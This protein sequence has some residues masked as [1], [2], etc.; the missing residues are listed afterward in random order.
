[1]DDKSSSAEE[2]SAS[3][4]RI[5]CD[6]ARFDFETTETVVEQTSAIGQDRATAALELAIGVRQPGYNAYVLGR[7]GVGKR[8]LVDQVL[9]EAAAARPP[10]KDCCYVYNF[11]DPQSPRL[12]YLPPGKGS[13]LK[14]AMRQLVDELQSALKS[15][16]ES[17]E[18]RSRR[19][20]ID[21]EFN[22]KPQQGFA[23]LQKHAHE[24]GLAVLRSPAGIMVAPTRNDEVLTNEE[25]HK[26]PD[27]ERARLEADIK[28]IETEFKAI[29]QG[30]P[31]LERERKDKLRELNSEITI[32]AVSLP[33]GRLRSQFAR[34][35]GVDA[36]INAIEADVIENAIDLVQG[37]PSHD[38]V[39]TSVAEVT[40]ASPALRRFDINVLVDHAGETT[41]PIV[42]EDSPTFQDLLGTVEHVSYMGNLVTDFRLIKGGSLHRA[43]GGYLIVDVRKLLMQPFAYEGLKRALTRGE[44]RIE[45]PGKA[46][47]LLS[48]VTLAPEPIPLDVKVVLLGDRELYY[49]ISEIDP[50]FEKLFKVQ[51]DFAD[52]IDRCDGHCHEL[53]GVIAEVARRDQLAPFTRAAVARLIDEQARASGEADKLSTQMEKL[54]DV[55]R[56]A[57]YFAKRKS[58]TTVD[59]PH[60]EEAIEARFFRASRI[61]DRMFEAID[62]DIVLIETEGSRIG[63]INAL[64]ALQLGDFTFGRPGRITARVSLGKGGVVD[65]EREVEL[66]GPIHSKGVMILSGFVA[67]RYGTDYPHTLGATLVFE[68]SYAGIEGDSASCAELLALLSAISDVPLRQSIAITGSINQHGGVQAIG[69]VNEKIEGFYEVCKRRGLEGKHGV[70]IPKANARHLMLSTEVVEA[71]SKGTFH[72]YA[73]STVDQAIELMTGLPA[74]QRGESGAFPPSS[75]NGIV[76]ARLR[77]FAE[78]VVA[79]GKGEEE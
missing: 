6:A 48:T 59:R 39:A 41:A 11:D 5:E 52:E 17:E 38:V 3:A 13:E 34:I 74:G 26:L 76:E 28:A 58:A 10:A 60:V 67:G 44:L 49:R 8:H 40:S 16:F 65:I 22:E 31:E 12:L 75:I 70:I 32:L 20:A 15:A 69:A 25:F 72:I 64:S 37:E 50:D 51:A 33:L 68:Q 79:F 56:E 66:G 7:E 30:L 63:Q 47:S 42:Y 21:E 14:R 73:V 43:N 24:Q 36:F 78:T 53:A 23:D 71:V 45:S 1:M 4:L 55:M 61:R 27:A 54:V 46:L 62:R 19:Q 29:I 57:D 9:A 18:Y 35:E 2:L 77:E